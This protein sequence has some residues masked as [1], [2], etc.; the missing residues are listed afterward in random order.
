[1][2]KK[3]S[4]VILAV[5]VFVVIA[6]IQ[7]SR[8]AKNRIYINEVRSTKVSADRDGYFGSDY[9]EIY[10]ASKE[11]I[12]LDGWYFSDDETH[13]DKCVITGVNIPG[14][15]YYVFTSAGQEEAGGLNFKISSAGEKVFLS[16]Q[17]GL[18]VDSVYV[19]ELG[20]GEVYA[21][22]KDGFDQ[23]AVMEE[24]FGKS[25]SEGNEIVRSTLTAPTFS[26]ESGF[27]EEGFVLELKCKLGEK[28]YYTL[29][30][31]IPTKDS[32]VYEDGILIENATKNPNVCTAVVNLVDNWLDYEQPSE[33]VDKA[34][35]VRAV[36]M[37]RNGAVSDVV[38]KTYFVNLGKYKNQNIF[39]VV[40]E[41]DEFFGE[42]GIFI[43]GKRYD[44]WY[45]S[46]AEGDA[47]PIYFMQSGREWEILGNL[48]ILEQGKEQTNQS[49]GI[50]THGGSSRRTNFKRMS[51]FARDIYSNSDYL[52]GF[53]LGG[54]QH[55]SIGTDTNSTSIQFQ[56]LVKN[57]EVA[58][59]DYKPVTVFL[60]GEFWVEGYVL[61]RYDE[62]H[63][64]QYF[65]VQPENVILIKDGELSEG[66]GD[67][68]LFYYDILSRAANRDLS[69]EE[70]YQKME[71]RM[72]IQSYIDYICANVY[73]CNMDVSE[74]KNYCLWRT[75]E[76]D[77]SEY[78]DGRFR[79]MLYDMDSIGFASL[80]YYGVKRKAAINSFNQKMEFTGSAINEHTLYKGLKQNQEFCKQFVLTFM[81]M[82]NIDFTYENIEKNLKEF[83]ISPDDYGS[84]FK[85]RAEYIVPY[86]AEEFGLTGTLE[87]VQ[88]KINN[89]TGGMIK[90]NTST[91]DLSEG[92]WKG[93]YYTD[94]PITVTAVPEDGY[95]F[96]GWSGSVTSDSAT[97]EAEII[98]GGITL[99]AVFEKI[100][101]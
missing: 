17:E 78:G 54:K 53:S 37:D 5:L 57:R 26:H 24:T 42:D 60:N 35:V 27:Y 68:I 11:E 67:D 18:V 9:I 75:R 19:P 52:E 32:Y 28:I 41:Y 49:V 95:K 48:E 1:M 59:Q 58:T 7:I 72:D 20:Y 38:T 46:G 76:N 2:K 101:N 91:P 12:S 66:S 94:Y 47:P 89:I 3:I 88:L 96:V 61:G 44:E 56:S 29:D 22:K 79:W 6:G 64:E 85:R 70:E 39:S 71:E 55:H 98:S 83:G 16:N 65:N 97:I 86:M 36:A 45:V 92:N 14:E 43:T 15:S 84:F 90:L 81:D 13:L 33:K 80:N 69:N 62:Y 30:G 51:F 73:L 23:W 25:N 100:A 31:S 77:G 40:G 10:N 50:R 82:V 63:L 21:R 99:E 8:T 93:A 74:T 4:M 34:T 87:E